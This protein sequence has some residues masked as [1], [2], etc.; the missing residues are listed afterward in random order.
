MRKNQVENTTFAIQE[1]QFDLTVVRSRQRRRSISLVV[2]PN[3]QLILRAPFRASMYS[4]E[5]MIKQNSNWIMQ[6]LT[7]LNYLEKNKQKY[8]IAYRDVVYYL[9]QSYPLKIIESLETKPCCNLEADAFVIIIKP[10]DKPELRRQVILKLLIAW[11]SKR[12]LEKTQERMV[13]WSR[14]LNVRFNTLLISRAKKRWGSCSGNNN[15]RIN[16]RLIMAPAP[17]L[18]Y[19]IVH[20]LCHVVHKNHSEKFWELVASIMPDYKF[21]RKALKNPEWNSILY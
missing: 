4:I 13:F 3:Y 15:I 18:D 14:Q 9:G 17:L 12:A 11:Y 2:K 1:N 16:W 8:E 21:Y 6:K 5:Q 19:V 7:Q 20:E 10:T